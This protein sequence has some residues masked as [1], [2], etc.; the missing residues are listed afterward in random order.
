MQPEIEYI[1]MPEEI[2]NKYQYFTK[3]EMTKLKSAGYNNS[4]FLLK[5]R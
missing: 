3:A 2:K 4:T 1:D 5:M